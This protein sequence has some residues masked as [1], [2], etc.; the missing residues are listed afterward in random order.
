MKKLFCLSI[1]AIV[2]LSFPAA[3]Q[4]KSKIDE[5]PRVSESL[6]RSSDSG[7]LFGWFDPNRF[8]MRH[9]YS[10]SYMNFGGQGLSLGVYTSSMFYKFSDPLDVQVDVSLI[11]SPFNSF[12]NGQNNFSG[13]FLSRALLNYHPSDNFWLQLQYR[14][15]PQMYWLGNNR[16]NYF[17]GFDRY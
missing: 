16:S 10:L 2:L 11:H 3:S 1:V 6:V 4:L 7:L 17:Y 13:L 5:P 15:V 8:S 14:Q 12:S 9:S